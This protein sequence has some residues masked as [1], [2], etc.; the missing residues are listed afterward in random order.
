MR[1]GFLS[2]MCLGGLRRRWVGRS[3]G[4]LRGYLVRAKG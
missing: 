2:P 4:E 3:D 1:L